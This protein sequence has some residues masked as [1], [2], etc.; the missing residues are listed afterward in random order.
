MADVDARLGYLE[1]RVEDQSETNRTLRE[2]IV[3]L[4]RKMDAGF[5]RLDSKMD[6]GFARL[7]SKMDLGFA[8]LDA[9]LDAQFRWLVGIQ[10]T[11]FA[12]VLG[13]LMSR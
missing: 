4:D 8:R 13:A 3:N 11:T 2:A 12:V 1:G 6:L 7:D 10:I 9:R 5:A